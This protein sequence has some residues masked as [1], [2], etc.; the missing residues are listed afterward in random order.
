MYVLPKIKLDEPTQLIVPLCLQMGWCRS[1]SYF[2][3]AFETG[4]DVSVKLASEPIGSLPAHPLEHHLVPPNLGD[5]NPDC[6]LQTPTEPNQQV[7]F[8]NLLEVYINDFI[9]LTQTTNEAQQLLHLPYT[10]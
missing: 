5:R 7:L 3:A 4:C 6:T 9:Q 2:C 10:Q 1:A 8:L